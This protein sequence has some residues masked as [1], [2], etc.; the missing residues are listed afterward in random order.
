MPYPTMAL[1]H[2]SDIYAGKEGPFVHIASC[3][4]NIVSRYV[5]YLVNHDTFP[6]VLSFPDGSRS[7]R[8]MKVREHI[9]YFFIAQSLT[10]YL[11][12]TPRDPECCVRRWSC[13][14]LR[15]TYRRC[16]VQLGRSLVFLPCEGDVAEV[17]SSVA[18]FHWLAHLSWFVNSFFC[19]MVAAMTLKFLDPFG[20]G[21]LVLFQVTYDRV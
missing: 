3:V 10:R 17:R 11:S 21:Q 19:A 8:T 12:Q 20:S 13:R 6:E 2:V 9:V 18:C 1:R 5:R 15:C 14:R 4:G 16:S 7:T